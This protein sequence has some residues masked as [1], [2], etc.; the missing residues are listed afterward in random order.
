MHWVEQATSVRFETLVLAPDSPA[1]RRARETGQVPQHRLLQSTSSIAPPVVDRLM[2]RGLSLAVPVHVSLHYVRELLCDK[3]ARNAIRR[4]DVIDLQWQ[5]QGTLI[6]I[7]R[8]LNRRARIVCTFHDVLSQRFVRARDASGSGARRTRWAWAA[9][10]ARRAERQILNRADVV[11]VLSEK[12]ALLLPPGRA[13]V[14]VVT[15]PLAAD[16]GAIDRSSMVPGEI[17]FVGFIARWENEE[18]LL[19]F[20][21]DAWP[22]IK[23][24]IPHARF[25]IVGLGIRQELR[26]AADHAGVELLGFV[27][28]LKPLYEQASVVVVP[29]RLGAGVKFK[30]VDAILAGVPVVTTPV[31]AEGIGERS[32]FAGLQEDPAGFADA[33]INVLSDPIAATARAQEVRTAALREYGWPRFEKS[34]W[35]AYE[36]SGQKGR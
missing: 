33:V 15:P 2:T 13:D 25:R 16:T 27:P 20:L 34:I 14:H 30:V 9:A 11:I 35:E 21:A 26:E 36:P 28:E 24:A 8:L 7:L 29:L 3:E 1:S 23:T 5:E 4:A 17:L 22:R 6:P 31:G 10:V 19:W 32:W 18:G 12:D